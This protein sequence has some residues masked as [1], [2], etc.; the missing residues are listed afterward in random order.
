MFGSLR[1][2]LHAHM[3]AGLATME[4]RFIA[5]FSSKLERMETDHNRKFADHGMAIGDIRQ[6]L[7]VL[8]GERA[9]MR[10]RLTQLSTGLAVAEAAASQSPLLAGAEDFERAV[11]TTILKVRTAEAVARRAVLALFADIVQREMGLAAE[12]FSVEGDELSKLFVVRFSG[13][14]GLAEARARKF[15]QLQRVGGKWRAHNVLDEHGVARQVF[16]DGDKN[17]KQIRT[18]VITKKLAQILTSKTKQQLFGRRAE[19]KVFHAW[20][21]VAKVEVRG[22]GMEYSVLWNAAKVEELEIPKEEVTR[23]LAEACAGAEAGIQWG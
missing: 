11:D 21:P 5:G 3:D 23:E 12:A 18:E 2:E 14:G 10:D 20:V 6:R 1:A 4:S 8:E 22:P 13:N 17:R 9:G 19:G 16:V 15:M 7:E